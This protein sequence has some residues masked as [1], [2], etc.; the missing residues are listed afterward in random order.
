MS[1]PSTTSYLCVCVCVGG[2]SVMCSKTVGKES[3][4]DL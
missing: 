4:V 1:A 2:S 3:A